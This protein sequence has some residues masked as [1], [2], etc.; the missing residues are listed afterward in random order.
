MGMLLRRKSTGV[1]LIDDKDRAVIIV[2][3]GRVAIARFADM[4]DEDKN[5]VASVYAE[6]TGVEDSYKR[7]MSFLNY[8]T[9]EETFCS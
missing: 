4:S 6:L 8:K 3:G 2:E 7:V 9:K 1:E 5:F